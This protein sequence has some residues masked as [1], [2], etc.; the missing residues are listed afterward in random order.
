MPHL[1]FILSNWEYEIFIKV[2]KMERE[3]NIGE[4]TGKRGLRKLGL[5]G[6][7]TKGG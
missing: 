7:V 1:S 6:K 4:R 3:N 5:E 2:I